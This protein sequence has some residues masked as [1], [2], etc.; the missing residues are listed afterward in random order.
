M[1]VVFA[2]VARKLSHCKTL[3]MEITVTDDVENRLGW[4]IVMSVK[5][6]SN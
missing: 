4:E 3:T 2:H 6:S 1:G 5:D